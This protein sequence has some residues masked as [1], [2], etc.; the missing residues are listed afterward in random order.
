MRAGLSGDGGPGAQCQP[1]LTQPPSSCPGRPERSV[2]CVTREGQ[3]WPFPSQLHCATI[4]KSDFAYLNCTMRQLGARINVP[5]KSPRCAWMCAR[6][7]RAPKTHSLRDFQVRGAG[8]VITVAT[9]PHA[10][11]YIPGLPPLIAERSSP[12]PGSPRFPHPQ[13]L[14][15]PVHS[16]AASSTFLLS[17]FLLPCFWDL[18]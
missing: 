12:W 3:M 1:W 15:P 5:A 8:L 6:G 13:A 2:L 10:V 17:L 16:V 4:G 14:R 11:G 7:A 18:T 9:P